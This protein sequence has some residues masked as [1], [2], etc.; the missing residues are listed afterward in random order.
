MPN[1]N[2][3]IDLWS[4]ADREDHYKKQNASYRTGGPQSLIT[5]TVGIEEKTETFSQRSVAMNIYNESQNDLYYSF[6][7]TKFVRLLSFS[8]VKGNWQADS[9]VVSGSAANTDYKITLTL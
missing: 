5:G 1:S 2:S 9:L 3:G 6:D 8:A 4:A 7:G